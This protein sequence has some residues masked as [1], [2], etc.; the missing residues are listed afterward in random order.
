MRAR[1]HIGSHPIHPILVAFPIGLFITSFAFDLIAAIGNHPSVAAA[2]WYCIIA[3]L[4]VAACAAIAGAVDLFGVV[5]RGSSARGRGYKHAVL[6]LIVVALFIAV[7]VYRGGPGVMPDTTALTISA[8]GV[9]VLLVSGWLGGTLVYRNQIGVDHRY[10]NAGRYKERHLRRWDQEVCSED[11]L[12]DGQM[13]LADVEGTRVV[14]GRC[15]DGVVAFS[16]R[17]THRGG[18]LSDGALVGCTVQ[19]PWHGSQ[20]NVHDGRVVN[21]P[22]GERIE[23][24]AAEVRGGRVY[25]HP[26]RGEERKAA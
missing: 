15:A 19:C 24:F 14:V 18:P 13:I 10:A 20:F 17:C 23:G 1:A 9:L 3:G 21:G 16:D 5:P 12:S 25:V 8:V 26:R 7:A 2:G 11:E 4:I 6:N 22:A